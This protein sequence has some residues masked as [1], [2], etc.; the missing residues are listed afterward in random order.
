MRG[1][2]WEVPEPLIGSE[3]GDDDHC[4]KSEDEEWDL[5]PLSVCGGR[6]EGGIGRGG[7]CVNMSM[8]RSCT[9]NLRAP[10]GDQGD[11]VL[12]GGWRER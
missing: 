4:H 3:W 8:N 6:G 11:K 12:P 7:E 1:E 10:K 2:G 5:D 9:A